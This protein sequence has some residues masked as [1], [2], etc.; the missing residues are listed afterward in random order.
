M[1]DGNESLRQRLSRLPGG[2]EVHELAGAGHRHRVGG[3]DGRPVV[4]LVL[5][6]RLDR[7]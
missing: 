4:A 6:E 7:G 5:V 2:H 1:V 3:D